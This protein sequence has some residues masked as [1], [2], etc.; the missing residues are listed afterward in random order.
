LVQKVQL[1]ARTGTVLVAA[2]SAY[3]N[4]IGLTQHHRYAACTLGRMA[5]YDLV[6]RAKRGVYQ[7][8]RY[9]PELMAIRRVGRP[10]RGD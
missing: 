4:K 9:H 1:Q 7:I 8:N 10:V 2:L 5:H 6:A 3:L